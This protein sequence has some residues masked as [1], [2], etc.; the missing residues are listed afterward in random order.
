MT[1]FAKMGNLQSAPDN[2][3][4]PMYLYRHKQYLTLDGI[5]YSKILIQICYRSGLF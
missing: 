2:V 3:V 1:E 4:Q 5:I